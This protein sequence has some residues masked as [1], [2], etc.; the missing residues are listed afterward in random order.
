MFDMKIIEI[1]LG[2]IFADLQIT[3][4]SHFVSRIKNITKD[5]DAI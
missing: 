3:Q 1:S 2:L 4:E 5:L